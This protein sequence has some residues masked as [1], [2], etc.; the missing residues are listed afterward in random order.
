MT[1]PEALRAYAQ[2]LEDHSDLGI[3]AGHIT[4]YNNDSIIS[5]L[6][7]LGAVIDECPSH[8]IVFINMPQFDP[9]KLTFVV[10]KSVVMTPTI[11]A[12]KIVWVRKPEFVEISA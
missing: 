12:E 6:I 1:Y 7:N 8:D 4:L 11:Q 9:L 10:K 2:F 5:K 3:E